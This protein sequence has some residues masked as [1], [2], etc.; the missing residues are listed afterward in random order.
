MVP[1]RSTVVEEA[2]R[3]DTL[4]IGKVQFGTDAR[5]CSLLSEAI[6]SGVNARA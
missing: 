6:S 5:Y 1:T 2:K 3:N 4:T